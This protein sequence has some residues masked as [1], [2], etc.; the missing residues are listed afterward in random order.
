MVST[1]T[2]YDLADLNHNNSTIDQYFKDAIKLWLDM[3]VDGIRV[4]AVKHMPLG[5]Q[6]SWM[7]SIYAH[8]PIFYLW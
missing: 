8:K 4:D 2:S 7:S 5:W 3:G 1:K 6:K